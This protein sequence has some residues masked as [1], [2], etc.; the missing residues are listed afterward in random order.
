MRSSEDPEGQQDDRESLGM[1][2]GSTVGACVAL[3]WVMWG[4]G[5]PSPD[6]YALAVCVMILFGM[7]VSWVCKRAGKA[8]FPKFPAT[9]PGNSESSYGGRVQGAEVQAGIERLEQRN[10]GR[11]TGPDGDVYT[12]RWD[13]M[14]RRYFL[15]GEVC[16]DDE[17]LAELLERLELID[18]WRPGRDNA[19]VAIRARLD[20]PGWA[21]DY[22]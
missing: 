2:G 7:A 10:T 6:D 9:S 14:L 1:L 21:D 19:T 20:L 3:V 18:S 16:T 11:W 22:R 13:P 8:D 12:V 4:T 17:Q 5:E 15:N